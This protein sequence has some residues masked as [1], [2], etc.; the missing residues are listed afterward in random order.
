MPA[1]R[2]LYRRLGPRPVTGRPGIGRW[3]R[4]R[5]LLRPE[6]RVVVDAGCAFGF[7]TAVLAPE[8]DAIGVERDAG[9]AA[10]ARR[11]YPALRLVRGDVA[12]LPLRS[13]AADAV[14]LLDV[15]E[16][17]PDPA[18]ALAEARR[19]L[20]SGGALVVSVPR[21]GALVRVDALNAYARVAAR[22]GWRCLDPTEAG[23][24]EHRHFG[25]RELAALLAGFRF[26]V[27]RVERTGLG[28]AELPHLALLVLLRGVLRWEG[29]YRAAR[30]L[31]FGLSIAEDALPAGPL[32]YN[33]YVRAVK[34]P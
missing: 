9:Y 19:V 5:R 34:A 29:A 22:R 26:R 33:L 4:A 8:H 32:A 23:A 14:L 10:Q 25:E 3:G 15:L 6:E 27:E 2:E 17:L 18:A 7:G 31:A 16:H 1:L 20:R 12:A 21:R 11:R 28:L 13:G 30:F 24:P